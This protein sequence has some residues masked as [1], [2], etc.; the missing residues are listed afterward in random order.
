MRK[1]EAEEIIKIL[2]TVNGGCHYCARELLDLF[3]ESFPEYID[4]VNK[5]YKN[6][7]NKNFMS[8]MC[9]DC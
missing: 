1:D 8:T 7:F 6:K 4:L 2:L 3:L 9:F 5:L